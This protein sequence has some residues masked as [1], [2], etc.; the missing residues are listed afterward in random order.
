MSDVVND[1]MMALELPSVLEEVA[2]HARSVSGRLLV[3]KSF[4]QTDLSIVERD[5]K[6]ALEMKEILK[7]YGEFNFSGL[8]PL[9]GV[10]Q[11][12]QIIRSGGQRWGRG[13]R[14]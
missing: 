8:A 7:L 5:L 14:P 11:K 6:L 1:S 13:S 4:P 9:E 2:A 3:L 12:L 10:F